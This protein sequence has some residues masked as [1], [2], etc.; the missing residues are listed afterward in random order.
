[1]LKAEQARL[2]ERL[3]SFGGCAD[4]LDIWKAEGVLG[5]DAVPDMD[6]EAFIALANE[7]RRPRYDAR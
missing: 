3:K 6:A 2:A 4:A 5:A 1:M 7:V